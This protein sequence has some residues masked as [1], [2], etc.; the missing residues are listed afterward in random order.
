MKLKNIKV[1]DYIEAKKDTWGSFHKGKTY[2]VTFIDD[3]PLSEPLNIKALGDDGCDL[4]VDPADFRKPRTKPKQLDQS[5]FDGLDKKWQFVAV[6]EDGMAFVY[7]SKPRLGSTY[8]IGGNGCDYVEFGTGYDSTNWQN[9]LIERESSELTGSEL[10]KAM[11][12]RGDKYVM[13][14]V[15][16]DNNIQV[17]SGWTC[18][19]FTSA[20]NKYRLFKTPIPIN[21]Q[22]EPLTAS[23]AGL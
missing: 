14:R 7:Q 23:E 5:V 3:C 12:A 10:C 8:F 16:D 1:G 18:Y 19:G 20:T 13:C 11:L 6:D 17:I 21:N 9:S 22:G 2:R 4:W 15:N